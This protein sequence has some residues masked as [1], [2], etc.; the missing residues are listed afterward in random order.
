MRITPTPISGLVQIELNMR[1]D[2]RGFFVE[3]WRNTWA[4]EMGVTREFVQDNHAR[5]EAKGVVRGLHFQAPPH[6]Q[7]KLVWV[8]QG[9]VYDVAVDLRVGSP[10]Y[11]QWHGVLLSAQNAVRFYVPRGFAHGYMTLE[12]GTEVCYK[13]DDYYNAEAEG[14]IAYN[15]PSLAIPWPDVTPVLSPKDTQLPT[16]QEFSSPFT[17]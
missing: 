5:S 10:T 6:A 14:G 16:L 9:S 1:R 12:E 13:V 2:H 17:L 4:Q 8:V 15:C 7:A 11:G 3:T